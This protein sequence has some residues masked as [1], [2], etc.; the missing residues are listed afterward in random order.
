MTTIFECK[1]NVRFLVFDKKCHLCE[2]LEKFVYGK[3]EIGGNG[4]C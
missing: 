4:W 3:E 2:I 1:K